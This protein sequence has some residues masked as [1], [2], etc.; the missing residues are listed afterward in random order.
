M[1][2]NNNDPTAPSGGSP[3]AAKKGVWSKRQGLVVISLLAISIIGGSF[4]TC[5]FFLDIQQ[6]QHT[7]MLQRLKVVETKLVEQERLNL[8]LAD[9]D[10]DL[11]K[12]ES[13]V[14]DLEQK[15]ASL[16]DGLVS[17]KEGHSE[18]HEWEARYRRIAA[19]VDKLRREITALQE[20]SDGQKFSQGAALFALARLRAN[21]LQ[22]RP[23]PVQLKFVRSLLGEMGEL[24]GLF[25][26][27]RLP[28]EHGVATRNQL[29]RD[30]RLV[31][32][33]MMPS[34]PM[35][36]DATWRERVHSIFSR[37]VTIRPI[38]PDGSSQRPVDI[39]AETEAHLV[40]GNL[41]EAL[42]TIEKLEIVS[43]GGEGWV[44]SLKQRVSAIEITDQ[45]L[46]VLIKET[47]EAS[48][49]NE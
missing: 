21:L 39:L 29:E 3:V 36:D 48:G 12:I 33:D 32:N 4:F 41:S 6:R 24:E 19:Q 45:I 23:C 38:N 1:F 5:K 18:P 30:F 37:L 43:R 28:C 42:K 31:A 15:L 20:S 17:I 14:L 47:E 9:L 10:P 25:E 40:S 44:H 22:G 13:L 16:N 26:A 46:E 11:R 49:Q 34:K 35:S 8:A 2:S 7:E 27:L